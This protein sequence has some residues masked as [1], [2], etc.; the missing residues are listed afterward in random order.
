LGRKASAIYFPA[1]IIF[2]REVDDET[3]GNLIL[4]SSAVGAR[5]VRSASTMLDPFFCF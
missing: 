2:G 5:P 1:S 3:H 4:Y